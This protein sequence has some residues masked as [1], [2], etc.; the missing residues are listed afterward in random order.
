MVLLF[1]IVLGFA[2]A[3][4]PVAPT[5]SEAGAQ[6]VDVGRR[7][8][9]TALAGYVAGWLI[10]PLRVDTYSKFWM[11]LLGALLALMISSIVRPMITRRR[12]GADNGPDSTPAL[13]TAEVK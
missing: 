13:T 10:W 8:G 4:G 12:S 3:I 9:P 6:W 11:P 1:V 7:M 2:R 5:F